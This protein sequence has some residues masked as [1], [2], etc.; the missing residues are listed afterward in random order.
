M[1]RVNSGVIY[2]VKVVEISRRFSPIS[3]SKHG[4]VVLA[5]TLLLACSSGGSGGD[6]P[7]AAAP[8]TTP[9]P[10]ASPI[11]TV[12]PTPEPTPTISPVVT[13]TPTPLPAAILEVDY[14]GRYTVHPVSSKSYFLELES[15]SSGLWV[16]AYYYRDADAAFY[17]ACYNQTGARFFQYVG[18]SVFVD[19]W[20]N[21]HEFSLSDRGVTWGREQ[22]GPTWT[23]ILE[24]QSVSS[25]EA[26]MPDC[27]TLDAPVSGSDYEPIG[28]VVG[29]YQFFDQQTSE[30]YTIEKFSID[31]NGLVHLMMFQNSVGSLQDRYIWLGEGG[32]FSEIVS[33][34]NGFME[35]E[36]EGWITD[37]ATA[38][39]WLTERPASIPGFPGDPNSPEWQNESTII[40][41]RD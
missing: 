18:D 13:A 23:A 38:T 5:C 37:E 32:Q 30:L 11:P 25:D 9:V 27:E 14:S 28:A 3:Y 7:A 21:E 2:L 16:N 6:S 12:S 36:I 24:T 41:E 29:N 34:N 20:G 31:A 33:T 1:D 22:V 26:L 15:D 19:E 35:L 17:S 4:L 8:T 10:S 40:G 39:L